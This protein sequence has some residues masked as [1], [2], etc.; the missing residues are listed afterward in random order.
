MVF[1]TSQSDLNLYRLLVVS[2]GGYVKLVDGGEFDV[3]R[4]MVAA[5]KLADGDA[6]AAVRV[7]TGQEHTVLATRAGYFLKCETESIP[8]MKKTAAGVRGMKLK[9]DDKVEAAFVTNPSDPSTVRFADRE[10]DLSGLRV[11]G[12]G[13]T[14]QLHKNRVHS[15]SEGK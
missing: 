2:A 7:V 9:K 6:L 4:K 13:G 1:A 11:T 3:S 14:G 10:Y 5:T 12:R 15:L 8:L